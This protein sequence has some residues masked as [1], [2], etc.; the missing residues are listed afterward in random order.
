MIVSQNVFAFAWE[1]EA[2]ALGPEELDQLYQC[3][4]R[5]DSEHRVGLD[6]VTY[7]G[8]WRF[9]LLFFLQN[10]PAAWKQ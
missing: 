4:K 7:P 9:F 8:S 3:A 1:N 2:S 6:R 10:A 5:L